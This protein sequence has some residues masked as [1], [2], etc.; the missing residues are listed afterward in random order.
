MK[1]FTKFLLRG[2]LVELAVAFIIGTAFAAVVSAFTAL[3]IAIIGA[4]MKV[5]KIGAIM[6]G[7]VDIGRS[8]TR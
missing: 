3:V 7:S 1:G 5:Q 2:N 6:I 8:S 4:I